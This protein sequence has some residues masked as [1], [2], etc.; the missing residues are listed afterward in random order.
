MTSLSRSFL[1]VAALVTT[2]PLAGCPSSDS[3]ASCEGTSCATPDAATI[4][5]PQCV[6]QCGSAVCGPDGC[7]GS[8]G[9]CGGTGQCTAE[10]TC[11][12]A[13]TCEQLG[14]DCGAVPAGCGLT[15]Q[16][17]GC[18]NGGHCDATNHCVI[19][20]G[21]GVVALGEECD[22]G[23]DVRGDGCEPECTFSCHADDECIDGDG[24][25]TETCG[26]NSHR[27]EAT[28]AVDGTACGSGTC[29]AGACTVTCTAT[30]VEGNGITHLPPRVMSTGRTEIALGQNGEPDHVLYAD[31][32]RQLI[33]VNHDGTMASQSTLQFDPLQTNGPVLGG[34]TSLMRAGST[35]Y[36][37]YCTST[38]SSTNVQRYA[39][40]VNGALVNE[41]VIGNGVG[42]SCFGVSPDGY[43]ANNQLLFRASNIVGAFQWRVSPGNSFP[44]HANNSDHE[45][46]GATSAL[47]KFEAGVL[48]RRTSG[49]NYS[50]FDAAG[51]PLVGVGNAPGVIRNA[52]TRSMMVYQRGSQLIGMWLQPGSGFGAA[53]VLD[54]A[55]APYDQLQVADA[56]ATLDGHLAFP[57]LWL[58]DGKLMLAV[59][60]EG[61]WWLGPIT[62]ASEGG[63]TGF[64][65]DADAT[66]ISIVWDTP[67]G[68]FYKHLSWCI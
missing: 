15:A 5:T 31:A 45:Y 23:N 24:C 48:K 13:A 46:W 16:C 8:C 36:L 19:E 68:V 25:A 61:T 51:D 22:D 38:S 17:G 10:G 4:D 29:I 1:L 41:T 67:A 37:A 11:C 40:L 14:A 35:Y 3:N 63:I 60:R 7:G 27:C 47:F 53:H 50:T 64:D 52:A 42:N 33:R 32:D 30:F 9:S 57:V 54:T 55:N 28:A 6:P 39:E 62:V 43:A 44:P 26:V 66:G 12:T 21:D 18:N 65:A 2:W 56:V 58:A 20:C 34:G 49:V 59:I